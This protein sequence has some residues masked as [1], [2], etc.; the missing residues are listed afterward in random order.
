MTSTATEYLMESA[1]EAG[2]LIAKVNPVDW[3]NK[4]FAPFLG[5]N[6]TGVLDVGCGP[7]VI[8]AEVARRL[9]TAEVVGFDISTDRLAHAKQHFAGLR[10][11][12]TAQGN[13][14]SLPFADDSFDLVHC[15]F[16]LEYLP[17]PALAPRF[18]GI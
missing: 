10:N 3:V 12:R 18:A 2:R 15:R 11:A 7:G 5:D 8:A 17:Q 16:L 9:P 6:V 13:A 4:H 14:T 1:H